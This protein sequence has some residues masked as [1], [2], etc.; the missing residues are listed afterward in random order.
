MTNETK[1]ISNGVN[2]QVLFGVIFLIVFITAVIT[3][4]AF[5]K[6]EEALPQNQNIGASGQS[7]AAPNGSLGAEISEKAQ[8]PI[9]GE[10]PNTN[11]VGDNVNPL[12]GAYENP[13][14]EWEL[15]SKNQNHV[16]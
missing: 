3:W 9:K 1:Q 12:E 4:Y 6:K 8:N 7:S 10:L 14:G 13:F 15:L 2:K 11:P 5:S 16:I